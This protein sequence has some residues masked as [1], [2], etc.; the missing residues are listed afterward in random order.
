MLTHPIAIEVVPV[1]DSGK[2]GERTL[3][4][5]RDTLEMT[6]TLRPL[7]GWPKQDPARLAAILVDLL[8][9]GWDETAEP[10]R[11]PVVR[12]GRLYRGF[13]MERVSRLDGQRW[14]LAAVLP[15]A[16]GDSFDWRELVKILDDVHASI[17]AGVGHE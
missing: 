10:L 7:G 3:R 4:L 17:Y 15:T 12:D 6:C 5:R 13:R 8:R 1:M 2:Q 11:V 16:L 9:E 14:E